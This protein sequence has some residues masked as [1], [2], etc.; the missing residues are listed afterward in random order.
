G[1]SSAGAQDQGQLIQKKVAYV[2]SAGDSGKQVYAP[3]TSGDIA[4]R[5]LEQSGLD[6][7]RAVYSD[8]V[9]VPSAKDSSGMQAAG[10]AYVFT[11]QIKADFSAPSPYRQPLTVF[12]TEVVCIVTNPEGSELT[13]VKA[14][15]AGKA[16]FDEF[17]YDPGL[18]ARRASSDLSAKLSDEI[19]KNT[20]LR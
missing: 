7:L 16:E 11:P 2:M 4:S 15:G 8:V 20:L 12:N 6:A 17:R 3:G 1:T 9:V 18:A 13:R 10:I 14:N 19:R 5:Q